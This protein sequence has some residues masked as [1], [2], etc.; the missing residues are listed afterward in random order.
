MVPLVGFEPRTFCMEVQ[1]SNHY[2]TKTLN[3]SSFGLRC[4]ALYHPG[5]D[6]RS[7]LFGTI[8]ET[9]QLL[10]FRNKKI[11]Q[12]FVWK[13]VFSKKLFF[14]RISPEIFHKIFNF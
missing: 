8:L 3:L 12:T 6:Y 7:A 1:C 10:D 13:N 4:Y 14:N 5:Q 2:T 9:H 11:K